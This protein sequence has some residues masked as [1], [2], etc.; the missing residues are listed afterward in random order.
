LQGGEQR[1]S[2]D[3]VRLL[4]S[5]ALRIVERDLS[6]LW[7]GTSLPSFRVA[8]EVRS[9]EGEGRAYSHQRLVGCR[10]ADLGSWMTEHEDIKI[11][12][13]CMS[14]QHFAIQEFCNIRH[15]LQIKEEDR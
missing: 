7:D 15:A 12:M 3:R 8:R 9:D 14:N 4:E 10:V 6:E 11:I 5:F 2:L 1:D 13:E